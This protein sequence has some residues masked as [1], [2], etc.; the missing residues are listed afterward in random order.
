MN[1]HL[2]LSLEAKLKMK[3]QHPE[4]WKWRDLVNRNFQF[5]KT[6]CIDK[7]VEAVFAEMI[8]NSFVVLKIEHLFAKCKACCREQTWF[9][10][11]YGK[12]RF[13]ILL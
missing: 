7:T 2:V 3:L 8:R 12:H 1:T 11:D 10:F 4:G 13:A 5:M 6:P 9:K